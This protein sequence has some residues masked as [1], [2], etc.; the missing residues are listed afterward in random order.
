MLL[1]IPPFLEKYATTNSADKLIPF[2][3]KKGFLENFEISWATV[4]PDW[5]IACK[6]RF[7]LIILANSYL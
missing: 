5:N 6:F 1:T 4:W 2:L 3:E 7:N